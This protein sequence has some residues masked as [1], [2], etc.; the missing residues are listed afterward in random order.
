MKFLG[1]RPFNR[2]LSIGLTFLVVANITR[3]LLERHSSMP[4]GPRDG[5]VGLLFGVAIGSML[6]GAWRMRH[7]G[8]PS[9]KP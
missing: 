1:R 2:T 7:P 8:M 6:L 5:V 4:E 3:V 9:G